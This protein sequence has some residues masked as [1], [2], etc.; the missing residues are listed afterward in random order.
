MKAGWPATVA[1]FTCWL[2]AG[3]ACAQ[4]AVSSESRPELREALPQHRLI[5]KARLT[6]WGFEVYDA[7]LWAEGG[8]SAAAHASLPLALELTYLR[9]FRAADIASRSLSEMRRGQAIGDAQAARWN[10][11]LLRVIPDVRKGDR[12]LAAHRPGAGAAFW[13]NGRPSGEIADAEFAKLFF[14]IWLSPGTSE[15]RLRQA[16]LSGAGE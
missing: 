5:G 16:L 10:A 14:G 13:V 3:A 1:F 11:G 7:R 6:V 8:F 9:D 2:C 12:I 4:T 15:P